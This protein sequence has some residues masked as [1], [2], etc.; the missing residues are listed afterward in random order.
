VP[1]FNNSLALIALFVVVPINWYVVWK[2][3]KRSHQ[4]PSLTVLRER[5]LA[6][7]ALAIVVTVYALIF[8]NNDMVQPLLPLT[9]T[10]PVTRL[11]LLIGATVPALYWL[12]LYR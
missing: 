9:T 12:R 2:L 4:N 1:D 8:V 10:K 6:A 3:R 7:L 11:V 5:F